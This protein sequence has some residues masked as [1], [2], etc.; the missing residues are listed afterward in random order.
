MTEREIDNLNLGDE[1]ALQL[2]EEHG[3]LMSGE[4][5][6]RTIGFTT[7]DAFRQAKLQNRLEISVFSL[8]NRRGTFAFTKHVANWLRK[9]AKE[10]DM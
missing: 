9:L 2:L 7:A 3:P 6:W 5:L 8:P 1:L 10:I 4:I